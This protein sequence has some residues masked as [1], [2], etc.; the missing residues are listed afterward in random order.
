MNNKFFKIS[1][2]ALL[3]SVLPGR[4][5]AQEVR[6]YRIRCADPHCSICLASHGA[7][8]PPNEY[9]TREPRHRPEDV[10]FGRNSSLAVVN[11]VI[12]SPH[13]KSLSLIMNIMNSYGL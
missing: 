12:R 10:P 13:Q 3:L 1:A 11:P 9:D 2:V 8:L 6:Q 7:I 5:Y 4:S